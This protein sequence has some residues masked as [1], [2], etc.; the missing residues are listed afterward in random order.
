MSP[1]FR[2][3]CWKRCGRHGSVHPRASG[4]PCELRAR[5]WSYRVHLRTP[6]ATPA[7]F[8]QLDLAAGSPSRPWGDP[9]DF[10]RWVKTQA[11][12]SHVPRVTDVATGHYFGRCGLPSRSLG[13]HAG[14]V[15]IGCFHWFIPALLG[16]PQFALAQWEFCS[17]SSPHSRG[18]H[19]ISGSAS[20]LNRFIPA[21]PGQP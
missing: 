14:R 21:L 16:Q 20:R 1:L 6:G 4:Q 3:Y 17:G 10:A 18:N 8:R 9:G 7:A 15:C 13:G 5:H 19:R 12:H 11:V 2:G